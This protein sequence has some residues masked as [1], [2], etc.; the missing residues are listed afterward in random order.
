M[1][2]CDYCGNELDITVKM[3]VDNKHVEVCRLCHR[4]FM[5]E[6]KQRMAEHR[7]A[8]AKHNASLPSCEFP[9][10]KGKGKYIIGHDKSTRVCAKHRKVIEGRL[11]A[12]FGVMGLFVAITRQDI[13]EVINA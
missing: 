9:G 12:C 10:C 7:K 13:M 8:L 5:E 2:K 1:K 4:G 6:N 3:I 11:Q